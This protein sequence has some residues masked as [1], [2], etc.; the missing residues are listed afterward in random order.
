MR[1]VTELREM[2]KIADDLRASGKRIGVVPTMGFLHEGHLSLMR[3]ARKH[4]D[5]VITTLFVNP[6]QFGPKEDFARY[7]RDFERDR[8]LAEEAGSDV[9]FMPTTE[10]IYP[11][12][13][14][15]FVNVEGITDLLE[16]K[17]RPGHFRGV[18]T[19][20]AKLF[21]ITKP[22]VAVFGQKDAQQAAV[23]RQMTRDLNFDIQIIVAP[24]VREADGL[25]MSSRNSYLSS[26][27]RKEA[28]VLFESLRLAEKRIAEGVVESSAMRE[29]MARHM[30]KFSAGE[31]DYISI[32]DHET[33][34]ELDQMSKGKTV[35]ISM[36]VRFGTTRLIDNIV[37]K[38]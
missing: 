23:I 9:L 33:L 21:N 35:L 13:Y 12:G 22:H 20:V 36:A 28:V 37:V 32:A 8:R 27:Q 6:T 30:T 11:A 29:E 15:T 16:G 38:V 5:F 19:V 1:V 14:A 4:S 7:P 3:I 2:Q 31:I 34:S 26:Q 18:A 10:D 17:S 25:A 24:I